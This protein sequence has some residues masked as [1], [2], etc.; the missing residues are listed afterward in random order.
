MSDDRLFACLPVEGRYPMRLSAPQRQ[1][2]VFLLTIRRGWLAL[3]LGFGL[4]LAGCGQVT[5]AG[6]TSLTATQD[7]TQSQ[8]TGGGA[9]ANG[10]PS[11]QIPVDS[12]VF[13]PAVTATYTLD[14]GAAQPV[15]LTQ[16]QGLEI[17][18]DPTVQWSLTLTDPAHALDG[19]TP[20]GWYDASLG[21]CA[22]RF[23]ASTAGTAHLAFK[24][25]ILCPPN[26]R[27][28]AV[29]EQAAFDVTVR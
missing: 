20:A 17:Y 6:N 14:Q 28:T 18:L 2:Q 16:G 11:K 5:H 27:C 22:W 4:L 19:L 1:Q 3:A 21:A 24:G 25:P 7:A 26:I 12:G 23:T 10:C 29:L 9:T 15:T 8:S 13:H